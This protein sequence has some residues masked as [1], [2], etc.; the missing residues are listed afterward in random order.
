MISKKNRKH[1]EVGT[2]RGEYGGI[3]PKYVFHQHTSN[4]KTKTGSTMKNTLSPDNYKERELLEK[5]K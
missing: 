5:D 1:S 3:F 4:H 2:A